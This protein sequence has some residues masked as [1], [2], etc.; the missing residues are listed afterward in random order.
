MKELVDLYAKL[1]IG[2][3]TFIGPSFT[4]LISLSY[5][6]LERAKARNRERLKELAELGEEDQLFVLTKQNRKPR[7]LL[8]PKRQARR[9]FITLLIGILSIAFY[10]FQHSHFWPD[11]QWLRILTL[12]FSAVAY[13]YCLIVLWQVFHIIIIAKAEEEKG[14]E[15]KESTLKPE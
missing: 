15:D 9:L 11:V 7:N 5:R 2:T 3:F 6:E 13:P 4:L 8:N 10:Y 1:I 12:S 14:N